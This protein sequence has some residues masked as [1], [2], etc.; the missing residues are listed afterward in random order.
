M[1]LEISKYIRDLVDV[2]NKDFRSLKLLLLEPNKLP[3]QVL[4]NIVVQKLD[5]DTYKPF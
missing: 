2:I 3:H 5:K 4:I 1:H